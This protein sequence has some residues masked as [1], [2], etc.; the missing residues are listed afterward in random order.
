V[1]ERFNAGQRIAVSVP[2]WVKPALKPSVLSHFDVCLERDDTL[3]G[4]EEHFVRDGITIAGVRTSLQKSVRAIVMVRERSLSELLGDSENPS[5][6]EWQ[7][8]SPKFKDRYR[9]GPYTLRYVKNAPREIVRALM[10]PTE[11]RDFKL[12][13]HLFSLDVPTENAVKDPRKGRQDLPGTEESR[14]PDGIETVAKDTFVQLQKLNGGFRI[15]GT[16]KKPTGIQ[17]VAVWAAYEVRRGNPF[18][19]YQALDFEM[20]KPPIVVHAE[21]ATVLRRQ[22]NVLQFRVDRPDFR[23]TVKG[24]D[25]HRDV[26]VKVLGN[27]EGSGA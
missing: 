24:F 9:H 15:V 26:R 23:L 20:D 1:R 6:T 14:G 18:R 7:E 10:R 8:R 5:H 3:S 16:G 11:G 4:S 25:A 21:G 13:Q 27:D 19:Q 22:A 2:V 17:S 12:L